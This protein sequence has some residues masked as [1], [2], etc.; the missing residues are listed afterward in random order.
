MNFISQYRNT[1]NGQAEVDLHSFLTSCHLNW[2]LLTT[3]KTESKPCLVIN[4]RASFTWNGWRHGAVAWILQTTVTSA[5]TK[6]KRSNSSYLNIGLKTEEIKA[7]QKQIWC[8]K[9]QFPHVAVWT[10]STWITHSNN[11]H[12][13]TAIFPTRSDVWAVRSVSLTRPP[14]YRPVLLQESIHRLHMYSPL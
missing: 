8:L 6:H 3:E 14:G 9:Q 13:A 4:S 10:W 2:C 12:D 11:T 1:N 7:D 5:E